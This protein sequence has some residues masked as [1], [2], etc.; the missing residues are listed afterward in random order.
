MI[1][2][3]EKFG[4]VAGQVEIEYVRVIRRSRGVLAAEVG[5]SQKYCDVGAWSGCELLVCPSE[6]TREDS[7]DSGKPATMLVFPRPMRGASVAYTTGRYTLVVALYKPARLPW[8]S[9]W[10]W[11]QSEPL[12]EEDW[13]I[14][15]VG[16]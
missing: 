3:W 6:R 8:W 4:V 10:L 9:R 5:T 2:P 11:D 13:R 1:R 7:Y 16:A 12:S 14:M 15:R